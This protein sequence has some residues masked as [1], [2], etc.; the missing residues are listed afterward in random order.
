MALAGV[1]GRLISTTFAESRFSGG[2]GC[3]APPPEVG[4]RLDA[5]LER[6]GENLGPAS[7]P[8]AIA[9]TAIIPLLRI[10]G[11]DVG[12]RVDNGRACVF[13]ADAARAHVPVVVTGW[14][15][16]LDAV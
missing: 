8:R 15:E 10:L 7:S 3:D 2:G 12:S 14:S 1:R 5:L 6:A 13:G 11:Y 9:D 16:S 4:R